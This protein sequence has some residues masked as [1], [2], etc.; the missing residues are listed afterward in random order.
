MTK[1]KTSNKS[2]RKA[3]RTITTDLRETIVNLAELTYDFIPIVSR[4]PKVETFHTVFR[5]SKIHSYIPKRSRGKQA[6]EKAYN[7]L[8]R[9]HSRL[10]HTIFRKVISAAIKHRRYRAR[11]L[12]KNDLES[13]NKLLLKLGVDLS[14]EIKKLDLDFDSKQIT[15]PP[16]DLIKRLESHPLCQEILAE[17]L[18]LFRNGHY[19]ESVRKASEKFE[20]E[21]QIRTGLSEIGRGLMGKAFSGTPLIA[22]NKLETENEKGIQE[23]YQ[24]ITMGMMRSMRNIF[25]HGD[26]DQRSP[27]EAFEM[28]MIM[29]WLFRQLP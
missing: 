26:E 13:L 9:Y 23:G 4:S 24:L 18:Q 19:N 5:E 7:Q 1:K 28:L 10:P 15:I 6:L 22:L 8:F 2:A 21:I 27:E 12:Q 20:T 16:T 3:V 14:A 25:S 29:N 11:P 17:P